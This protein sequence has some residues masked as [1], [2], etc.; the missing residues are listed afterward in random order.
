MNNLRKILLIL[1]FSTIL[2][3]TFT[4]DVEDYRS[5]ARGKGLFTEGNYG[6]AKT[7]FEF[8]LRNYPNSLLFIN[9]YANYYIGMNYYKLKD[10]NKARYYLEQAVYLP[11]EFKDKTGYFRVKRNH[12]FEYERN[13]YLAQVY[14]HL[15]EEE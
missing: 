9:K 11:N 10:Y 6:E 13:Y 5:F 7:E 1:L 4:E 3:V 2:S 15:D 8:L 12:F 14:F